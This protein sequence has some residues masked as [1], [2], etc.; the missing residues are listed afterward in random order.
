LLSL[1]EART[2]FPRAKD[3]SLMIA[4]ARSRVF[5]LFTGLTQA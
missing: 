3:L 4:N 5:D 1:P 2:N